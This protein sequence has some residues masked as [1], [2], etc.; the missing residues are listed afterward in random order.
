MRPIQL[1][2]TGGTGTVLEL[3]KEAIKLISKETRHVTVVSV[4]GPYRTGKSYLLNRLMG[5]SNGFSLGADVEAKT[6]GFW[7]WLGDYPGDKKRCLILLDVE[8]LGDVKKGNA[9]HDL[10]M[11][12]LALLLSSVFIYNTMGKIDA[13]ALDGLHLATK[14]VDELM[15]SEAKSEKKE[16][17][18]HFPHFIWAVRDHRLKLKL[19]GKEVTANEYLEDCLE[20]ISSTDDHEEFNKLR[21]AIRIFFPKRECITF[22]IPVTDDDLLEDLENVKEDDLSPKFKETSNTFVNFVLE[23]AEPKKIKGTM[24]TGSAYAQMLEDFLLSIEKK[25]T[26]HQIHL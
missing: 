12:T 16:F 8:G 13:S 18:R 4:I 19:K 5:K 14:I 23:N 11:F 26:K 1:I 25:K 21:E 7:L 20:P 3:N 17:A 22:P 24:L 10:K 15:T 2:G 9:S 6:K